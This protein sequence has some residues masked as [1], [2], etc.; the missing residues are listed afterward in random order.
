MTIYRYF[1]SDPDVK[2]PDPDP[3]V[4]CFKLLKHKY[5]Q[6]VIKF[7]N[8]FAL[9]RFWRNLTKK[10]SRLGRKSPIRIRTNGPGSE[11]LGTR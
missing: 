3:S 2:N 4:F 11:T 7:L 6:K 5:Q 10:E 8:S 9:I 1:V